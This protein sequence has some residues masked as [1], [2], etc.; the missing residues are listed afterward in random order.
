MC[1]RDSGTGIPAE[2]VNK[3]TNPF[4]TTKTDGKRTGLGLSISHR[5]IEEHGGSLDIVSVEGQFTRIDVDLP[6]PV[7]NGQ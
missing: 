6:A 3:V 2:V 1:F 5:I 4:F 7:E